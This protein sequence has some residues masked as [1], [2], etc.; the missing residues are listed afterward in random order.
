MRLP[1]I[2]V[3]LGVIALLNACAAPP[4]DPAPVAAT[5]LL[6]STTSDGTPS[7]TAIVVR[8]GDLTA[9]LQLGGTVERSTVVHLLP[10]ELFA[11]TDTPARGQVEQGDPV[12]V[13]SVDPATTEALA[14][15]KSD[16]DT[17]RLVQLQS[18]AGKLS[19]PVTGLL[20]L[21]PR[22][23]IT[24]AGNDVVVS[25]A[26]LQRLRLESDVFAA[27]AFVETVTGVREIG[28]LVTWIDRDDT[29]DINGEPTTSSLHCRLPHYVETAPGL[30]ASLSLTGTT[31]SDTLLV[32]NLYVGY[33]VSADSY[34][35]TIREDGTARTVPVTVG[36]TDGV[37]RAVLTA[38]PVGAELI[39][40][41]DARSD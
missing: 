21:E 9:Q 5:A 18:A 36:L 15:S 38:L 28:C 12:G 37:M 1:R 33:E 26:P 17:A 29:T 32:P 7:E 20:E 25:L 31:L 6:R 16:I 39:M 19:A 22:P 2:L 11:L 3:T 13:M 4:T 40:P 10:S 27:V 14:T 34:T 41:R 8:R 30:R 23:H 24:A 35:V